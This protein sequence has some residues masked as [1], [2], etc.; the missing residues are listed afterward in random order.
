MIDWMRQAFED[1]PGFVAAVAG[2]ESSFVLG[3][4]SF[5]RLAGYRTLLGRPARLAFPEIVGQGI[6]EMIDA[7][8]TSG[9]RRVVRG[10]RYLLRDEPHGP[11][12]PIIVDFTLHALRDDEGTIWGVLMLGDDVTAHHDL[13]QRLRESERRLN[14]VLQNASVAIFVMDERQ[15]CTYMNPAAERLTGFRLE[16]TL[17]RPLHDV[18]HHTR[19]DGTPYP[20]DECPI[21]RAFPENNQETGEEV[22]VHR[23]GSFFP[24][25]FTA[26]PLRDDDGRTVGTII[27]VRDIRAEKAALQALRE[28]DR[29][30]DEFLATLAHELRNPLSPLTNA[31]ALMTRVVGDDARIAQALSMAD[32]QTRQLARLVDDLL[33]V[34]RVT[35]GKIQLRLEPLEVQ[36]LV[37]CALEAAAPSA[38]ARGQTIRTRVPDAP[39]RLVAD[40]Q[41]IAQVLENLLSNATKFAREGG[42]IWI[43]VEERGGDVL[44]RV[45]DDGVG[46][47]AGDVDRLFDLFVQLDMGDDRS[48]GGLGI[49][50]ALVRQLVGLHGGHVRAESPG[51]GLGSTFT[52]CLPRG[53]PEPA[54]AG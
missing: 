11:M 15:H 17:G 41:R 46:I 29:R 16:E 42:V 8:R 7:V 26:S 44:L 48:R 9:E 2:T 45:C 50:L 25:A 24:V 21:D 14:G 52:V 34:G 43:D 39:V 23:D 13:V 35:T 51:P 5:R 53:G 27:E 18:V 3:N 12:R 10:G 47:A 49:G 31:L 33:D 40:P 37:A 1:A 22:F 36:A 28:A 54:S 32:R 4:A 20:L 38:S 19:P 6:F 30:K